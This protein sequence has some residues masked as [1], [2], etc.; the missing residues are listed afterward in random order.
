MITAEP[1]VSS[2]RTHLLYLDGLRGLACLT[3]FLG[4]A[5]GFSH[6]GVLTHAPWTLSLPGY[7]VAVF[8][9]LSG[10]CLMLPVV[11][12][13][14]LR[15]GYWTFVK[16]RAR[17]ILPPYYVALIF[18]LLLSLTIVNHKFGASVW[19][20]CVPVSRNGIVTHF[21]LLHNWSHPHEINGPL[22]TIAVEWQIYFL[23][24]P[25]VILMRRFGHIQIALITV[26][27]SFAISYTLR[28]DPR[29]EA[30]HIEF[31]GFF[32]L[33]MLTAQYRSR[34]HSFAWLRR[35]MEARWLVAVGTFSY[36]LYLIH[37]PLQALLWQFM[38]QPIR[39]TNEMRCGLLAA[40]SVFFI[41]PT[42]RLFYH[43][44]ERPF[45]NRPRQSARDLQSQSS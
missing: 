23:F 25:L 22:W 38:V 30:T 43:F 18:S 15:G 20:F 12:K 35:P 26:V 16:R 5:L 34:L 3:V 19:D 4:H 1:S 14:S 33:G 45:L 44:V 31:V 40:Y 42:A 37:L 36:S 8:I 17:R 39:A 7:A 11:A 10:I 27:I 32:A 9:W 2:A 41:I 24:P 21:L 6:N 29:F 28:N 13:G